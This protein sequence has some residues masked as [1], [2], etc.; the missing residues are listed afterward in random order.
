MMRRLVTALAGGVV[1]ATT[2]LL[3]AVA[4]P[5]HADGNPVIAGNFSG[6]FELT[7]PD[8][9][10]AFMGNKSGARTLSFG[11]GCSVTGSC[12]LTQGGAGGTTARTL[13]PQ[14]GGFG[15]SGTLPIGCE[16]RV[17]H[18]ERTS[19]GWDYHYA[20]TLRPSATTTRDGV[21]Y[22]TAMTGTFVATLKRTGAGASFDCTLDPDRVP[23]AS[24][25]GTY[26]YKLDPLPAPSAVP[27]TPPIAVTQSGSGSTTGS[28]PGF[29]LP[30]TSDQRD[31]AAAVSSGRRSSVPGALVTPGQALKSVGSRLPQDLLLVA[32]LGLLIVF[33]AQLFN[34]TYEENHERIDR[35]LAKLPFWRRRPQGAST[36]DTSHD[37]EP[38][39]APRGRRLSVFFGC[40]L[41]GTLLA[42]LLDP[43]LGANT[44]TFAMLT[45]VFASVLVTV[46]V[47]VL[48]GRV[49]RSV[50]KHATGWYLEAI[51][52]A[53][54]VAVVCVLVSR[55]T[56]FE[57]GYLYGVL[58][59]AVFVAALTEKSEG[60]A[61]VTVSVVALLLAL[62]AWVA[63]E[64]VSRS[65]NADGASYATLTLDAL[66]ASLFI[67][68]LEGMLFGLVPLR[69]LPGARIKAWSWIAWTALF[70]VVLYVFVHVLL[71]PESGYLGR[72]TSASVTLTVVLFG[73]FA[74]ISVAFWGYFRWRPTAEEP[75]ADVAAGAEAE[76]VPVSQPS[77]APESPPSPGQVPVDSQGDV[78][79]ADD[80]H[81]PRQQSQSTGDLS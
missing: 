26:T 19:H 16:D 36:P 2:L 23:S 33:P 40:V 22:V 58:G 48:A 41:L 18:V 53:L 61:E 42:G 70:V 11:G 28:V 66:L 74:V 56:H 3:V 63:F 69:F 46:L 52:S 24:E 31:S 37:P 5:A 81:V 55:L 14:G 21:T 38:A 47:V 4:S 15:W 67:G 8:P 30:L 35:Q 32:L 54:L 17:T 80:P 77:G 6:R 71:M 13:S 72:S 78:V 76:A 9:N 10:M 51:P 12:H 65:A 43:K 62:V 1:A 29:H 25:R 20:V 60:R 75:A 49:Y 45:G 64:P 27:L 50:S 34:S 39:V 57:P 79:P 7:K 73:A 44:A 59:G 68:G